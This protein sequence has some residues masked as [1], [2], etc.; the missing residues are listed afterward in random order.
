MA[1][2]TKIETPARTVETVTFTI[3]GRTA[4]VAKGTTVLQAAHGLGITIPSFC[5]HPKLKPVGAC[6]MC[7]VEIE[8]MPKLQ[9]SCATEV[10]NGMVVF[11]E[12]DKVKQG[13]RA[14]IEFTLLNHPLDC[15]TCDKGGECD[16]QNL[17][18]AHGYDDSRFAFQKLRKIEAGVPST[19]DDIKIGPEI[20]LN[21]NRCILCYKCVRA[22]K[23]A[24][25]E[26]DLGAFERGN[27]T[28]INAAP[29]QQ[30]DNP[31]SG[32]LVEICP[33]GALTN[34]DWRYKIR[35]WLTDQ[36]ASI[37]PFTS[38]GTNI[39]FYVER[40]KNRIF[41]TTGR[42]NDAIDDGWLSDVT[43]YGYQIIQSPDRL[44]TPLIKKN[45]KQVPATW[46]EAL[47]V[48][49]ARLT[50]IRDKKGCVCVGGLASP[51]L[52]N[53]S[54]YT[55]NKFMR[56][57]MESNNVDYR[58]EYRRLPSSLDNPYDIAASQ[59]FTI[60]DIDESDVI[61]VIGSDLVRE[62]PNEYLRVRK[63]E[64]FNRSKV[65]LL[66]PLSTKPSDVAALELVHKPG[67]EEIAISA[68]CLAAMES[69][70][71]SGV[72]AD[73]LKSKTGFKKAADAAGA[74]GLDLIEIQAVA[75]A[76]AEGKKITIIA[77]EL[78]TRSR[79]REA[80]GAALC[81][82]N[83]VFGVDGKG[84]MAILARHANSVGAARLG[85]TPDLGAGF[86]GALKSIWGQYPETPPQNTDAMLAAARKEEL[87]AMILVGVNP[88]MI[89]P[90]REFARE[91]LDKLDF[92]IACDLFET[93]TTQLADVVLPLAGWAEYRG[94]Y[95][96]LEGRLQSAEPGI[97]P[98]NEARPAHQILE[99]LAEQCGSP[100]FAGMDQR[101]AE[102]EKILKVDI[103]RPWPTG[104]IEVKPQ[105]QETAPE[106]T[107]AL[108]MGDDPHHSGYLTEKAPSLVGFC[109][110]AYAEL[111]PELAA[112][113]KVGAGDS[114]RLEAATGKIIVPVRVSEHIDN[115]V[116]FV[117]R[118]FMAA[119]VNS[120]VSRKQRVDWV[121]I[122][123]VS[124]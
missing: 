92:L 7:Y 29:G 89:Y 49:A 47:A 13:R 112:K 25:G 104:L 78:V 115:D 15:P 96:N 113:L 83:R 102:M 82:L 123:K 107:V 37:C 100:L 39:Q 33:V 44:K 72:N 101:N 18:F 106:R 14:I 38:S 3:N 23:E 5:W 77:G 64:Q 118:N 97:A 95:F 42:R 34:T 79:E 57:A 12:S 120:L 50:E 88:V 63:A 52:D 10:T 45:G 110:E 69:G 80:I 59:A 124:D 17:T 51:S 105:P 6:R 86:A 65:F 85:L 84:Q 1:D 122:S 30:V 66:N 93:E 56:V 31:F 99:S 117:P 109:G 71:A 48:A 40:H 116:V 108:I 16:L 74:C 24:F 111:S 90:D 103:R 41:R 62:H 19:F 55:F 26:Y 81:N 36:K 67:A 54:L 27:H 20:V 46:D 75:R 9:V 70:W 98:L 58:T 11:T 91:A 119:P 60:A 4:T 21:R 28:E 53:A 2:S 76:I 114:V 94:E 35:V 61:V 73:D 121:K 8:K 22:N 43:R 32:N 68:I 87:D